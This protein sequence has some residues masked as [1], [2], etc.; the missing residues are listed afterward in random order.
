[1]SNTKVN[2]ISYRI[3]IVY[4]M[5]ILQ[6]NNYSLEN[7]YENKKE[8]NKISYGLINSYWPFRFETQDSYNE[9]CNNIKCSSIVYSKDYYEK[10][11][12]F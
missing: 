8:I 11:T 2:S 10:N 3:F 12:K 9:I 4:F 6:F 5:I 1:M 7:I